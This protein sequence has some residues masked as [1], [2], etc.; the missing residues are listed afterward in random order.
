VRLALDATSLLGNRTGVGSFTGALVERFATRD[1]LDLT[2]F[3]V[4]WRGRDGLR[5]AAPPGVAVVGRP[6]AARPLRAAWRRADL[7]PVEW[8]TGRV[9][10]VHG[11]NF[12]VPPSR[13]AAEVVTVHDLTCVR[14]PELCTPDTLEY[15][16]LLARAARRGAWFHT[17]SSTVG[18][19]VRD[20]LGVPADRVQVVP[21]GAPS[22]TD[23]DANASR[24]AEGRRLAGAER[25][26]LSL[27]TIEPR[28][29][30]VGL[31]A[32]FDE[33][34]VARTDVVLVL[35]GPDGWGAD[36]VGAAIG[37]SPHR[38]RIRRLGWVAPG[39]RDALL[40]GATA[41]AYPSRYEGFGLPPLEAMAQRT[42]VV[43]TRAGALPEVLGDAAAWADVGDRAGLAEALAGVLDDADRREALVARGL[44]RLGRYDW[45]STADGLVQLYRR[46][47]D[48]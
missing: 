35:A 33:V 17:V 12:V 45:D 38:R 32:A 28:K 37:A 10:V 5:A 48:G 7:P 9:D 8:W 4:T 29:D 30:L 2:L 11:P 6:M 3:G 18:D 31:V 43:A 47:L 46:S 15:P 14:F 16:A 22:P 27:G 21:N 19:E 36:A 1:D 20:L 23:A 39:D 26:V 24:A 44:A 13:H 34:A 25:Y 41:F 42:P 40:A